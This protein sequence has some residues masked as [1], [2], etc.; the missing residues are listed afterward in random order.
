MQGNDL[1]AIQRAIDDLK[2]ASQAMSQRLYAASAAAGSRTTQ[3]G[4]SSS[5]TGRRRGS[6][7]EEVIDA[8][9]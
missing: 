4:P 2:Q 5:P 7:E 9:F 1:S 6:Q 8:E 3:N